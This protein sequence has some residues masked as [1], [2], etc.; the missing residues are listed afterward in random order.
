MINLIEFQ[1]Q[2]EEVKLRGLQDQ[3]LHW[4]ATAP[5][6]KEEETVQKQAAAQDQWQSYQQQMQS[7]QQ[8]YQQWYQSQETALV[9]V[10]LV[11]FT[12]KDM[13]ASPALYIKIVLICSVQ[14]Y[15][16]YWSHHKIQL[17]D[18]LQDTFRSNLP[19]KLENLLHLSDSQLQRKILLC[20]I[21]LFYTIIPEFQASLFIHSF[22]IFWL[23]HMHFNGSIT[24][25]PFQQ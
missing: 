16:S 2:N 7:Y 20:G 24:G 23:G 15:Q 11:C 14:R 22:I 5:V 19:A 17:Q 10:K 12:I 3:A 9:D 13:I 6:R 4:Q 18:W 8:Q 21:I 25:L 1:F